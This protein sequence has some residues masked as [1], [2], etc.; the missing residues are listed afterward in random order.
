MATLHSASCR[1]AIGDE[2]YVNYKAEDKELRYL[3]SGIVVGV[4]ISLYSK[5]V[6]DEIINDV[7]YVSYEVRLKDYPD[8]E[9]KSYMEEDVFQYEN[10]NI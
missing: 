1:Y 10:D 5:L 3:K 2:V 4:H 7:S 8:V 6:V 9:A